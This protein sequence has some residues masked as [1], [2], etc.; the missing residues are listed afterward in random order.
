MSVDVDILRIQRQGLELLRRFSAFCGENGIR[1]FICGGTLLGAAR[2]GGFIPWDDDVDVVVPRGDFRRL[3]RLATERPPDGVF[4]LGQANPEHAEPN[5]FWGKFC[6]EDCDIVDAHAS[7][8]VAHRFG[9]DVLPLDELPASRLSRWRQRFLSYYYRHLSSLLFGGTSS[10]HRGVKLV[11][12]A[13]LAPFNTDAR[14]VAERFLAVA[15]IGEGSGS[16]W[17]DSLCGRYGYAHEQ[18]P[19]EWFS[20][21]VYL[22][23]EGLSLPAAIGWRGMLEMAYGKDWPTPRRDVMEKCHYILKGK[24]QT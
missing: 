10:R 1:Y 23:F 8:G 3:E 22:P 16:G 21:S 14:A 19:A 17:L 11:L 20:S 5:V 13:A 9:I 2:D 24:E 4:W 7:G 15:A 18:F 6:L 12:R